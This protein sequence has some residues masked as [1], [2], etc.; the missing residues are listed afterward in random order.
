MDPV[1]MQDQ[2]LELS[3]LAQTIPSA[4]AQFNSGV[5]SKDMSEKLKRI[6]KLSKTLRGETAR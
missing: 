2:A 3:A 5:L 1:L 4:I 6:E